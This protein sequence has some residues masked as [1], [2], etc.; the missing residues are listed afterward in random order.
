VNYASQFLK[1][2]KIQVFDNRVL[3]KVSGNKDRV[4]R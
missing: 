1:A 2:A 3:G 4:Y